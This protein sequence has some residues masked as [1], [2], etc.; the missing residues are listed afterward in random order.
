MRYEL[1][2]LATALATLLT[3]WAANAQDRYGDPLPEGALQRL[4]AMRMR[5][6][7]G[8]GDL[9]YLPDGRAAFAIGSRVEVCDMAK[10]A[11]L[12]THEVGKS[13]S[14]TSIVPRR[15]GKVL[16]A[17]DYAGTVYEWD[18]EAKRSLRTWPTG[19][20]AVRRAGYSPDEMRVLTTG[21][22]PP[23]LKEWDITTAKE[24]VSITGRMHFFHEGI[25]GPDGKTAWVDGGA[26]SGP[27][28]AHYDLATGKL[29]KELLPDY[30]THGRSIALSP[31]GQRVLVGS[32]HKATE[33][34][35]DGYKPLKT[36]TGHHGHAVTSVAY[37]KEPDQLLTGSR[38]GS[39]RRWNRLE[40]KVRLRWCPHNN[41]VTRIAVS[42]DGQWVLSYGGSMVAETS[43]A[44]GEPRLKWERHDGPV[45]AVAFLPDGQLAVSASADATLRVWDI[46]TGACVRRIQGATLGAYTVAVSPDGTQ[47]AAGCKDGLVREF[48]LQDGKL[49]RELKGHLGYIR[50]VAYTPDGAKLLSSADDGSI[51][52]WT[53][54]AEPVV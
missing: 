15:D 23:T 4:G 10:G 30:Y 3:A 21:S 11:L 47:V 20:A 31:D 49:L 50:S 17:A 27:V 42:P 33:W 54:A 35:L 6:A 8:I 37:C 13:S 53:Q 39:I 51:R 5:Y 32:R 40:A 41:H 24:L 26:G 1:V 18:M 14:L 29:L 46:H 7:G 28:L 45:Q 48:S 38:D 52:V 9:C 43:L 12:A 16:L 34:Q 25:Y 2:A 36:F 19:Q 22:S 44:T